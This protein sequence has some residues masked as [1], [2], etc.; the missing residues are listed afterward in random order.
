M[1]DALHFLQ[2]LAVPLR[3]SLP[4][5]EIAVAIQL[6]RT[7]QVFFFRFFSL[8]LVLMAPTAMLFALGL[9]QPHL[10][11]QVLLIPFK[12]L[13]VLE[14][15]S[16]ANEFLTQATPRGMRGEAFWVACAGSLLGGTLL[17][18][19]YLIPVQFNVPYALGQVLRLSQVSLAA[20]LGIA[21]LYLWTRPA[22]A[23]RRSIAHLWLLLA[24]FG[25]FA[26]TNLWTVGEGQELL[27][28]GISVGNAAAANGILARWVWLFRTTADRMNGDDA[29]VVGGE[30]R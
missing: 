7:G 14:A 5:L 10:I 16:F 15:F 19:A 6:W 2:L 28:W 27:W 17:L 13:A 12:V 25:L 24:W 23:P 29:R 30:S 9:Y 26:V 20:F 21:C 18:L 1:P 11:A 22:V 4:T 8:Y 3:W